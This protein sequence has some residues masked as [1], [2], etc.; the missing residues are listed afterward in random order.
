MAAL[1][2]QRVVFSVYMMNTRLHH[3]A[4]DMNRYSRIFLSKYLNVNSKS[5][6]VI[7]LSVGFDV[8][9]TVRSAIR[10]WCFDVSL[11]VQVCHS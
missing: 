4:N 2:I 5:T 1:S 3:E 7:Q 10:D 8:S 6:R 11:N 9:L